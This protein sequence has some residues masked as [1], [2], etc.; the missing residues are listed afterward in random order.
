MAKQSWNTK[1]YFDLLEP[2]LLL[3]FSFQHNQKKYM[4][5]TFNHFSGLNR[6]GSELLINYWESLCI[7]N[8]TVTEMH[9][10]RNHTNINGYLHKG[11][12]SEMQGILSLYTSLSFSRKENSLKVGTLFLRA[13]H[14]SDS[15]GFQSWSSI[16]NVIHFS[17]EVKAPN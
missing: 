4:F 15:L 8:I 10:F 9:L 16:I 17:S 3:N 5:D 7:W 2:L 14:V 6:S 12:V 1:K 11:Q 13:W